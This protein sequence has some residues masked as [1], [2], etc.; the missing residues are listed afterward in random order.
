MFHQRQE[1]FFCN[2][3]DNCFCPIGSIGGFFGVKEIVLFDSST[4]LVNGLEKLS[5]AGLEGNGAIFSSL[6]LNG[7]IVPSDK[8]VASLDG[9]DS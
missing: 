1:K 4:I 6:A 5:R 9:G 8:K 2:C 3:F 7:E